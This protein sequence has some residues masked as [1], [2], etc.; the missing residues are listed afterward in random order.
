[1]TFKQLI[2]QYAYPDI[3]AD[4][5]REVALNTDDLRPMEAKMAEMADGFAAM[6]AMRPTFGHID[7][8][9]EVT[10]RDGRL[11]V[12]NTHLGSTSD[13]LSHRV[14]VADDVEATG[15]EILAQCVYQI[16]AHQASTTKYRD[17]DDFD[18]L[19]NPMMSR[20]MR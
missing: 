19:D 14:S 12:S 18:D 16:V 1:M 13:L 8:C 9:I 5:R 20:G 10:R 15:A 17:D 2:D 6:K 4:L 3:A 11:R 7:T